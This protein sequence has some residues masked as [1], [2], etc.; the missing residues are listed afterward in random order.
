MKNYASLSIETHLFFARIM[1]EHALF[2][3]AGFP[4]KDQDWIDRADR[5]RR[6]FEE[7]LSQV[8]RIANGN[9]SGVLLSS[10]ELTTQFTLPAE[11]KT[12]QLSG[13]PINTRLTVM[14]QNLRADTDMREPRTEPDDFFHQPACA[15]PFGRSDHIQRKHPAGSA[16]RRTV[17]RKLSAVDQ[18]HHP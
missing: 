18:A 12:Q 4:C 16:K 6:Q 11:R 13:I 17:H 5:F 10:D 2:L 15:P 3:E 1:K 7:L 14:E 9:I 8:I